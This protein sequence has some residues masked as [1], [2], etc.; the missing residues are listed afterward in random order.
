MS[1]SK[2]IGVM[3]SQLDSSLHLYLCNLAKKDWKSLKYQITRKGWNL[4]SIIDD[5]EDV[6]EPEENV[7]IMSEQQGKK[8]ETMPRY[9]Q[10]QYIPKIYLLLWGCH[11]WLMRLI[12]KSFFMCFWYNSQIVYYV[13]FWIKVTFKKSYPLLKK[14]HIHYKKIFG[15]WVA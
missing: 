5:L 8:S 11:L 2:R 6:I 7:E 12:C 15:G 14:L 9:I 13:V 10:H 3:F 4:E 1:P